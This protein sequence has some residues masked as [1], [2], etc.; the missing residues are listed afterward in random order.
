MDGIS[1]RHELWGVPACIL[2]LSDKRRITSAQQSLPNGKY[3]LSV[4]VAAR[5]DTAVIEVPLP[6]YR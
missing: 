4:G 1:F 2:F 3:C 5:P 6:S